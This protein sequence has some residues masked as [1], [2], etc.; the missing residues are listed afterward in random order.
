MAVSIPTK[1]FI[2]NE[3][4]NAKSGQ[5]ITLYSSVDD[6]RVTSDVQVAG[7][8]DV[9]IAV[10]AAKAAFETGPWATFTGQQRAAC[11]L[12]FADL[13]EK[14]A[15]ELARLESLHTGRTMSMISGFDVPHMCEVFRYYAGWADKIQGKT[16][17]PDNGMY[18]I[19]NYS[20]IGV[21][22]GMESW[23]VSFLYV[24]WKIAPA[25]VMGN[26]V[27]ATIAYADPKISFTGSIAV[28][29]KI[30][31]AAAKSNL[32]KVT[33]E[34]GG[35]VAAVVFADAPFE[36]AIGLVGGGFLVNAGQVCAA[37]SRV[38]VQ[39]S[40]AENF[41][42]ALKDVFLSIGNELGASPMDP[43]SSRGPVVDKS[44]FKSIMSYIEDGKKSAQLL[45]GGSQKGNK[46]C[47]IEPTLFLDPP[48]D[49]K[50]WR[51]EIFGPVLCVRTFETEEEAIKIANDTEYG[52]AACIYT[53]DIT[54]ALRISSRLQS[55]NVAVN[56][57]Y[58]P[59]IQAPFGGIKQS[60]YGTELGYEG[61]LEWSHQTTITINMNIPS[62]L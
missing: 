14:N 12:R 33:L 19:V 46:S 3:Y 22:A 1:L 24:S 2:N 37:A 9:D 58:I 44:Q 36:A 32:K 42:A 43:T 51:E 28:A 27:R 8:E 60:G 35:N 4:V 30:Q 62:Q 10:A 49:N 29:K 31:E 18:K 7:P 50:V 53:K 45:A 23:N 39:K 13:A 55:G 21:C 47:F 5:T 38:L 57:P 56:H 40:I 48:T 34:L 15:E 17:P 59:Q 26:T 16:F 20:P 61:L 11:L 25:L 41:I 6:S 54:R 52:L